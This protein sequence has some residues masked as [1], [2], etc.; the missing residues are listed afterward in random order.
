MPNRIIRES[1]LD[2]D[3]Y[4]GVPHDSE[5]LLFLELLLLADDYGIVP[6]N[7]AFLRRRTT[8]CAGKSLEVVTAMVSAL[9]D[10]DLVRVY[11]SQGGG[12]FGYIPRFGNSPRS[13]KPKWPLPPDGLSSNEIKA[14]QEKRMAS[15]MRLR[16]NA[17][18]TETETE[19]EKNKRQNMG[20][21][22]DAAV[23]V[24]LALEIKP[25]IKSAGP[26]PCP[27]DEIVAAYHEVLPT[28]RRVMDLNQKRQDH[29]RARW[30]QVWADERFDTPDGI[31]FF[32]R[33]FGLV[34][35]SKFLTGR[36]VATPGRKPFLASL[37]WL[38]NP[39]NF[40]KVL[41]GNYA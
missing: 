41:E 11:A 25:Q 26:P 6:L 16:A 38:M 3:R 4:H 12:Q 19:T 22:A 35:A 9:A 20:T 23:A 5:R 21:S 7:F 24:D 27:F 33:F 10:Q 8:P 36:V 39:E 18:E 1:L 28:C 13:I 29:I 14:L 2:S 40:L 17:P 15:A 30:R 32:R 37:P 34:A 31:A